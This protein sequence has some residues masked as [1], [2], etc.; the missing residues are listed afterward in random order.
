[1]N[2]TA[3]LEKLQLLRLSGMERSYRAM[4]E[5][6]LD[7]RMPFE[8]LMAHVVE[9]E[10]DERH[11][12]KTKRL[13]AMAGFRCRAAFPELDFSTQRGLDK[14]LFMRLSDCSWVDKGRSIII[15][16][17]TGIGKS[18]IAQALGAQACTLGYK[19]QYFN[20]TKLFQTLK[21]KRADGCYQRIVS[22]LAKFKLL[23]LDDFGLVP[24]D[25]QDRLSLLELIEDR[26]DKAA[27]IFASQIPVAQWFDTI[28]DPTIADAIC[29]RIVPKAIR[30]NLS[31]LSMRTIIGENSQSSLAANLPPD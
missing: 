12:R 15:S 2:T 5:S 9:A 22:R 23:I 7:H 3:T 13:T 17:P 30:I 4:L 26:Y 25:S 28:G 1:M 8:E 31:G 27:T 20:C 16:G 29:D 10:W 6:H 14:S 11:N 21:Q 18:Y 24:M 19:T